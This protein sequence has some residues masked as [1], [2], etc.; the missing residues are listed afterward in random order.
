MKC[1][2]YYILHNLTGY[3]PISVDLENY[4][5]QIY[6]MPYFYNLARKN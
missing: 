4:T 3:Q 6:T 5:D 2:D 1:V